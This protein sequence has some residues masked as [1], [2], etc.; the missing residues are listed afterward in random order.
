VLPSRPGQPGVFEEFCVE[1]VILPALG[2]A[3]ITSA[4]SRQPVAGVP[5]EH[6]GTRYAAE[7]YV[8]EAVEH[9]DGGS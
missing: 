1:V 2:E 6:T 8:F 4:R 9:R 3:T 7:R 5:V